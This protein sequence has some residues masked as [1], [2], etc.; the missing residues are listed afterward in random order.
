MSLQNWTLSILAVAFLVLGVIVFTKPQAL[1]PSGSAPGQDFQGP[2]ISVGGVSTCFA[3]QGLA[4]ATTTPCSIK[5][6]SATSTLVRTSV[7]VATATS[8]ATYWNVATSTTAYSTS[9][10]STIG[11]QIALP[12]GA[13]GSIMYNSTTTSATTLV[14]DGLA[15]APNTYLVWWVQGVDHPYDTTK[16]RGFCT[17]TFQQL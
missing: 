5:S 14:S 3:R 11:A 1:P 15:I 4:L 17:A 8:T 16:L 10:A 12:S 7:M 13:L 9:S 6:P 2:C